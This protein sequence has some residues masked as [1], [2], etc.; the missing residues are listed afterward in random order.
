MAEELL[1]FENT[2]AVLQQLADE[3]MLKYKKQLVRDGHFTYFGRDRL[4]DTMTTKVT[5]DGHSFTASIN[6]N[7]Y[8]EY[9]EEG[10]GPARGRSKYWPRRDA[11]AQWVT[12]KPVIPRPDGNGRIPTPKQLTFLISRKI[13]DEGIKG[14][15]GFSKTRDEV[16]PQYYQRITD[17]LTKDI[18][19]YLAIFFHL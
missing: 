6:L 12:V 7:K 19:Q 4:V 5:V 17:A 16:I 11:I 9:L 14:T 8:W 18:S 13:H 3:F 2:E 1:T 10:T 15:H